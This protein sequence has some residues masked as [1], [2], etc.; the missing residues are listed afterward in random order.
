MRLTRT[1]AAQHK[2]RRVLQTFNLFVVLG[3]PGQL[4]R[5]SPQVQLVRSLS[6]IATAPARLPKTTVRIHTSSLVP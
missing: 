3:A 4:A 1:R 6:T 5:R 2:K